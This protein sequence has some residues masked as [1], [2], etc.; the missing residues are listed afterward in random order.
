[1]KPKA[2]LVGNHWRAVLGK[3]IV[4]ERYFAM[5][6][7]ALWEAARQKDNGATHNFTREQD[8]PHG[9]LIAILTGQEGHACAG[10]RGDAAP[11]RAK[12]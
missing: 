6:A 7:E 5:K 4:S 12:S 9:R 1:L 8:D 10:R 3:Q 11:L 2:W